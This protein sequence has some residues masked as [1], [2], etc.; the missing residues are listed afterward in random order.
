M[1]RFAGAWVGALRP[2]GLPGTLYQLGRVLV[3]QGRF[4]LCHT[5]VV[6]EVC[7]N[8]YARRISSYGPEPAAD[9]YWP[10]FLQVRGV[11]TR[12]RQPGGLLRPAAPRGTRR[13][14]MEGLAI[15]QQSLTGHPYLVLQS[16]RL[17]WAGASACGYPGV[18]AR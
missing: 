17:L 8:G 10:R 18:G 13:Q 7:A 1:A 12:A 14:R 3:G 11:Q 6:E 4:A 9:L 16:R 15:V 2:S 5:L